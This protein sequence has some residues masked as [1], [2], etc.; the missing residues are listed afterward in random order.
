MKEEAKVLKPVKLTSK[1]GKVYTLDFDLQSI[2]DAEQEIG[3]TLYSMSERKVVSTTSNIF[4]ASFFK[5]HKGEVTQEDTDRIYFEELPSDVKDKVGTRLIE[6]YASVY[7]A[8]FGDEK[9][10]EK[11]ALWGVEL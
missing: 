11:N 2:K 6:L 10:E 9:D 4:Y 1:D 3:F 7:N 5:N 8:L